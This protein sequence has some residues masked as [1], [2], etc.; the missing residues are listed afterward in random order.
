[1][2]LP[3]NTQAKTSVTKGFFTALDNALGGSSGVAG[4]NFNVL[5]TKLDNASTGLALDQNGLFGCMLPQAEEMAPPQTPTMS[6]Q[7]LLTVKEDDSGKKRSRKAQGKKGKKVC[8]QDSEMESTEKSGEDTTHS[9]VNGINLD[10]LTNKKRQ[11]LNDLIVDKTGAYNYLEDPAEYKKARKRQ[12]NRESAVRSRQRKKNYQEVLEDQI[13]A[14]DKTIEDLKHRNRQLTDTV[15]ELRKQLAQVQRG[16]AC[17]S[18]IASQ[19]KPA[20]ADPGVFLAEGNKRQRLNSSEL[21]DAPM[22]DE[23]QKKSSKGYFLLAAALSVMCGSATRGQSLA[24]LN[25]VEDSMSL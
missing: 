10:K 19:L 14:Q 11:Y 12:Q 8:A 4:Q 21:L 22:K 15:A 9:M 7:T 1:M 24:T 3:Y 18:Q 17:E 16:L 5:S 13:K 6:E 20:T 25:K 2:L 23:S